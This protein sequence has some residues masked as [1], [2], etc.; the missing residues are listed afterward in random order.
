MS[1]K[2]TYY[3]SIESIINSQARE[4]SESAVLCLWG[5]SGSTVGDYVL[6][7]V[8]GGLHAEGDFGGKRET[9]VFRTFKADDDFASLSDRPVTDVR[10]FGTKEE[11]GK[12]LKERTEELEFN[13]GKA[14]VAY[15]M[16]SKGQCPVVKFATVDEYGR[17][18]FI[19]GGSDKCFFGKDGESRTYGDETYTLYMNPSRIATDL[20]GHCCDKLK[21]AKRAVKNAYDKRRK[22]LS[23]GASVLAAIR[24]ARSN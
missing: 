6:D 16:E 11:F 1:L 7:T 9:V 3:K 19:E 14:V 12:V 23:A 4:H 8:I 22:E 10:Y 17:A 2:S 20:W 21:R 15:I 5:R 18:E 24:K 13:T